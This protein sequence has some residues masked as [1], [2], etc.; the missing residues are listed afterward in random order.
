MSW[1]RLIIYC[2]DWISA[3]SMSLEKYTHLTEHILSLREFIH[4]L[5]GDKPI[6]RL[7]FL[8]YL[9]VRMQFHGNDKIECT[10]FVLFKSVF[11][12]NA[13]KRET[14]F[15]FW[16]RKKLQCKIENRR[17]K[18]EHWF[19]E[20]LRLHTHKKTHCVWT[21]IWEMSVNFFKWNLFQRI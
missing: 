4:S 12:R 18:W 3:I 17:T 15:K 21:L 6:E 2:M 5:I 16:S 19:L 20:A 1:S 14:F 13:T 11:V 7:A 9:Y 8:L 10:I